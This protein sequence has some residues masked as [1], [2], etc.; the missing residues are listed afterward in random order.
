MYNRLT[1]KGGAAASGAPAGAG[2][3]DGRREDPARRR[4]YNVRKYQGYPR[5]QSPPRSVRG[6]PSAEG[7]R[8]AQDGHGRRPLLQH[9]RRPALRT[10]GRIREGHGG[11]RG[12]QVADD[13]MGSHAEVLQALRQTAVVPTRRHPARRALRNRHHVQGRDT[14]VHDRLV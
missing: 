5:P 9:V 8:R 7:A 2:A 4:S 10:H 11:F 13:L 12:R 14:R 1:G 3:D 6:S